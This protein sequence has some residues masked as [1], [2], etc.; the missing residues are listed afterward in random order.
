[1]CD[2]ACYDQ[3]FVILLTSSVYIMYTVCIHVH[4]IIIY[5]FTLGDL[6]FCELID[7]A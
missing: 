6:T 2:I 1:M 5:K 7:Y 4:V 3:H